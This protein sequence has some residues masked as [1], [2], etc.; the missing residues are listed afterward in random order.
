MNFSFDYHMHTS[1]SDGQNSMIE[2]LEAVKAIGLKKF[3]ISD[4]FE[5]NAYNT[6][7][8]S[9]EEY[10][11]SLSE[12]EKIAQSYGIE[13]Y[14]GIET[15]I[16][17]RGLLI[18]KK[19]IQR[20]YTIASVH[21]VPFES[22]YDEDEYWKKYMRM[23][24]N[25]VKK[26]NFDILGHV[27]GYMPIKYELYGQTDF[28]QR[29]QI[30][31]EIARKYF[32]PDWYRKIAKMMSENGIALEIH[33]ATNSPRIEVI[34]IMKDNGVKFSFGS[35]AHRVEQLPAHRLYIREVAEKLDLKYEDFIDLK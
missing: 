18:P 9:V 7:R 22:E 30:E 29:R 25:A 3:G 10:E 19:V 15:G 17:E 35:D 4:H 6:V 34:S 20:D 21:K 26:C 11:S 32:H 27:E 2:M 14:R 23:V 1:F 24:E 12:T 5:L 13:F 16:G 31:K 33:G 8:A 28:D